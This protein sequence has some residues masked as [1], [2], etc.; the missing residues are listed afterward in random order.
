MSLPEGVSGG[1]SAR[2]G[3]LLSISSRT[4]RVKSMKASSMD[5]F[6]I[7]RGCMRIW[8]YLAYVLAYLPTS[9]VGSPSLNMWYI[10]QLS[11]R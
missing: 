11:R 8:N 5:A 3:Y 1:T 6:S 2:Y 7:A 10:F 9:P 4:G